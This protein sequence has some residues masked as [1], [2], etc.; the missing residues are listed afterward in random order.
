MSLAKD[1]IDANR[2]GTLPA[3]FAER[4]RLSPEAVAYQQYDVT[5]ETW[6]SFTWREVREQ[7]SRWRQAL[8]QEGL[9][10]G[11]RVAVMLKNSVEWICFDQAAQS[12]GLVVVSLYTAD[13][14]DDIVYILNDAGARLLLTV[15]LYQRQSLALEESRVPSLQRIW[16]LEETKNIS[17]TQD[18]RIREV[19]AL[20]P[21]EP[22]TFVAGESDPD[23]LATIIYTSGTTGRPKGVMLSHRNI[24]TNAEAVQKLIPAYADDIFLSFLPLSHGFERTVEY[25]LPMMAGSRVVYARSAKLLGADLLEIRP[26]VFLAVPRLYEKIYAMIQQEIAGQRLKRM[27][28]NWTVNLGWQAFEASYQRRAPLTVFQRSLHALLH[29][30]VAN[31]VL[32]YLGGRLRVAI[33]G[34]AP[35]PIKVMRFFIG[36]GLPLYEGYG[37]TEAG[38]VVSSNYPENNRPGSVGVPLPGVEVRVANDGEL[39]VRSKS[40]MRGY[41]RNEEATREAIDVQG[42]LHTSDLGEINEGVITIRGRKKDILVTS[43]GEKVPPAD[44]ESVIMMDPLVDQAMIVGEGKPYLAALLILNVEEWEKL[45]KAFHL[46]PTDEQSLRNRAVMNAVLQKLSGLLADFPSYAQIHAVSLSC[47]PWS[48]ENGLLTPT[49]KIKRSEIEK[50]FADEIRKLYRGHVIVE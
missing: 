29:R 24:L 50:R 1:F 42:W 10:P 43:T 4:V 45:A 31:K 44:M 14:T 48:I 47:E 38:P 5:T 39:L 8:E 16:C 46:D 27:L 19:Q 20:L 21:A 41:W 49:M 37:L 12:L 26:T 23:A 7:V 30:L 22:T 33:T 18:K 9:Q 13:T 11:E 25:Y 17:S 28:F 35:I 6:R 15:S 40:V 34:A 3:L 2:A 36:L 32:N